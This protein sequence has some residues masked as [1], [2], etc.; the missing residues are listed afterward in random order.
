MP[1]TKALTDDYKEAL[2]VG[3]INH[4][5]GTGHAFRIGL[6][7]DTTGTYGAA[8][9]TYTE[10]ATT[11]SDEAAPGGGG[12]GYTATGLPLVNVTPTSAGPGTLL[13]DWT[14]TATGT[15]NFDVVW[16]LAGA[17]VTLTT[18]GCF[19]YND[20]HASDV[21]VAVWPFA[22]APLTASGIGATI[23]ITLPGVGI[24]TSLIRLA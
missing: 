6:F 24:G 11:N 3:G 1:I 2:S 5:A 15:T 20:T 8:T 7:N 4:T 12:T 16:T 10:I 14:E 19:I 13:I 9:T 21:V 22:G 23:T 17:G 18:D